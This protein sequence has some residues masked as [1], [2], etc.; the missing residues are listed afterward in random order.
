MDNEDDAQ[1]P[2]L[3]LPA[4]SSRSKLQA[5]RIVPLTE[6]AKGKQRA[7]PE[8]LLEP[9]RPTYP[10]PLSP[11]RSVR[12]HIERTASVRD[13]A[14]DNER[15][16]EVRGRAV[17]VIFSNEAESGGGNLE[18]WVEDGET[19]GSVKDQVGTGFVRCII[20]KWEDS[21]P[22][23][24]P[25]DDVASIDPLWSTP[26]GRHHPRTLASQPGRAGPSTSS[27]RWSGSRECASRSWIDGRGWRG[28]YTRFS[29]P[30]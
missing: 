11:K 7:E 28:R 10:P 18:L 29:S 6:K 16:V 5:R 4:T 22:S 8:E 19:V 23:F 3:P 15:E 12:G 2:L 17:T 27:D 24:V 14:E 25:C 30:A 21:S 9:E 1:T 26:Y 13:A 20:A